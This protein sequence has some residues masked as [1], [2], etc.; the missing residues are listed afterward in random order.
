VRIREK[1]SFPSG[2]AQLASEYSGVL[3]KVRDT[4]ASMHG[5]IQ[6]QGHTDNIPMA[7]ARFRSNWELSSARA[8]SVAHELLAGGILNSSRFAVA[9]YSDTRALASNDTSEDRARNRR[10]EIVVQQ[11]F[12]REAKQ[13]LRVLQA[14]DPVFY[15]SL[16]VD[17][18]DSPFDLKPSEVF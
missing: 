1:G 12:D 6:V 3:R 10:V 4:L 7:T 11:G 9:G 8:V 17:E 2:S 16:D 14:E 5:D 13:D 18:F 15:Q